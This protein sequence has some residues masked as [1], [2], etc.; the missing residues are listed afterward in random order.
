MFL[1]Y[2]GLD[3]Y[4]ALLYSLLESLFGLT[5]RVQIVRVDLLQEYFEKVFDLFW[6]LQDSTLLLTRYLPEHLYLPASKIRLLY[7]RELVPKRSLTSRLSSD[8]PNRLDSHIELVEEG[9]L[10][11]DGETF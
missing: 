10:R 4:Q 7:G 3:A 5:P 11:V 9:H 6:M 1:S 2:Y 8:E